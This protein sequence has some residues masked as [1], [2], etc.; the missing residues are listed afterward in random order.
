[1]SSEENA[2]K[3]LKKR[4]REIMAR[5]SVLKALN[6]HSEPGKRIEEAQ[7]TM[8]SVFDAYREYCRLAQEPMNRKN[9]ED[10]ESVAVY[11]LDWAKKALQ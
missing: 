4:G 11:L 5:A 6:Y 10:G 8:L 9:L 3:E 2:N 1:M 7:E